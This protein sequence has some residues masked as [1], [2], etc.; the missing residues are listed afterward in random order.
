LPALPEVAESRLSDSGC[1]RKLRFTYRAGHKPFELELYLSPDLRFLSRDLADTNL[2]PIDEERKKEQALLAALTGGNYP[3][4][5]PRDAPVVLTLFS[6][7]QC[8]YCAR[9]AHVLR[10]E[11]L[12]PERGNVRLVFRHLPLPMQSW[13][14]AAAEAAACAQEQG[15]Q[16]FWRLHDF[17]FGRQRELTRENIRQTLLRE[18]S[19][20]AKFDQKAFERCLTGG[21][22]AAKVERDV[23]FARQNGV[24]GTPTL[25]IN[26]RRLE[27]GAPGEQ[28][29]TLIRE[30][31][32]GVTA[33]AVPSTP[34]GRPAAAKAPGSAAG[35]PL[36]A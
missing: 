16:H 4:F 6:D 17:L 3:A 21:T 9:M 29:R 23:A 27:A 8:P 32:R 30:L 11:I 14:R 1:H 24:N 36:P 13:A 26:S 10:D 7:F 12:P 34:P 2:D 33:G 19:R 31:V 25:F 5:G 35:A 28:I 22:T 18:T 15:D 20:C